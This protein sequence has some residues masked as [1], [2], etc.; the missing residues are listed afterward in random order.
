M[1][2]NWRGAFPLLWFKVIQAQRRGQLLEKHTGPNVCMVSKKLSTEASTGRKDKVCV[3][4]VHLLV[5]KT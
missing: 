2:T 3:L 1:H 5:D 4:K